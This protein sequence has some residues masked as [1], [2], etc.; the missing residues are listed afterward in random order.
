MKTKKTISG[1]TLIEVLIAVSVLII[2]M[3]PSAALVMQST[4][5]TA[6]ARDNLIAMSLADEGIELMNNIRD[7]N[8][9]K[10]GEK[11]DLCW[12]T[13]PDYNDNNDWKKEDRSRRFL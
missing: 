10:F 5:S 12:D 2:V 4:R 7:A 11:F 9:L 13:R 3:T 1:E 6:Y 8:F